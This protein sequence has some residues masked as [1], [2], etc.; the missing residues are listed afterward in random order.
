M[1]IIV[2][3]MTVGSG[4][5]WSTRVGKPKSSGISEGREGKLGTHQ[6]GAMQKDSEGLGAPFI[7]SQV[8]VLTLWSIE[9]ISTARIATRS[10]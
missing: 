8:A 3:G 9:K 5:I 6:R 2:D 7:C 1:V 4:V 10:R